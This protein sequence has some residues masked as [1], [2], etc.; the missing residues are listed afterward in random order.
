MQPSTLQLVKR[1]FVL[2]AKPPT[3]S[4]IAALAAHARG[5]LCAVLL[6]QDA[7]LPSP[8]SLPMQIFMAAVCQATCQGYLPSGSSLICVSVAANV[9]YCNPSL[10]PSP[11]PSP[12]PLPPP[13]PK[14]IKKTKAPPPKKKKASG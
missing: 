14:G 3:S 5:L 13:S 10:A 7:L 9:P 6:P 1:M 8:A 4:R 2:V 11:S 12:P